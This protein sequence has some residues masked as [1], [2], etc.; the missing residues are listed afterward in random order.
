MDKEV[1]RYK[2]RKNSKINNVGLACSVTLFS[3]V[4]LSS[5]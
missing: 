5:M 1:Q 3:I 2:D 4:A